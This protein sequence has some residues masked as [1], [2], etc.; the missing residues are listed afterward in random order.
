LKP[1][2]ESFPGFAEICKAA[3]GNLVEGE[4][5]RLER[6]GWKQIISEVLPVLVI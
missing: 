3:A 4:C 5:A 2:K 6:Y 1:P